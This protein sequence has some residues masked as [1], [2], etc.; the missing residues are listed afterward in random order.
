MRSV[1]VFPFALLLAAGC[2]APS[3]DDAASSE[4]AQT[5]VQKLVELRAD[6]SVRDDDLLFDADTVVAY[7]T[8]RLAACGVLTQGGPAPAKLEMSYRLDAGPITTVALGTSWFGGN[9]ST[10]ARAVIP[11]LGKKGTL[12]MWFHATNASGCDAWDSAHGHNHRFDVHDGKIGAIDFA[13]PRGD[14]PKPSGPLPSGGF[15]RVKYSGDRVPGCSQNIGEGQHFVAMWRR[16]DFH[17]EWQRSSVNT[18]MGGGNFQPFAVPPGAHHVE[19]WFEAFGTGN[20]CRDFDS[21]D[22]QNYVFG[23]E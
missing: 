19:L 18:L 11:P 17:G 14:V 21:R 16:F 12:E 7:D 13:G 15:V 9:G 5:A 20:G 1:Y 10:T 6:G 8:R 2:T 4:S 23:L 3:G 22:G